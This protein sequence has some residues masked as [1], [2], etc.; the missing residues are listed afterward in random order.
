VNE[1]NP[2]QQQ[3]GQDFIFPE[4]YSNLITTISGLDAVRIVGPQTPTPLD[5]YKEKF[6][7]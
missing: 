7:S 1:K 5:V 2:A 6:P 3:R 4:Y